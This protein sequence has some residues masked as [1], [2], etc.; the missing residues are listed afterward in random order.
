MPQNLPDHC[1]LNCRP[2]ELVTKLWWVG[3]FWSWGIRCRSDT[4]NQ[5]KARPL[6]TGDWQPVTITLQA[7]SL[8]EKAGPIQV[9]ILRD[10]RSMY[11]DARRMWSLHGWIPTWQ[12][13]HVSWSLGLKPS[14]GG[15]PNTKLR[16]YGTPT[17]LTT[18][19]LFYFLMCED[20]HEWKYVEIAFGW[21]LG[22]IWLRT[23]LEGPWPHYVILEVCWDDGLWTLIFFWA[24]TINFMV[25]ALGSCVKWPFVVQL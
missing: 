21:G 24:L 5:D 3:N 15:R 19:V 14:L 16:D 18:V 7:L 6:H 1:M 25:T 11:V 17:L 8:V 23:M 9:R 12:M 2:L 20:P 13:D 22:H 4:C 10:Q